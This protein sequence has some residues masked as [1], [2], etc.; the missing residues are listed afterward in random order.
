M[1][2][3]CETCLM[4][5]NYTKISYKIPRGFIAAKKR[6]EV[7]LDALLRFF[8]VCQVSYGSFFHNPAAA[9]FFADFSQRRNP[10]RFG[11][12]V[13]CSERSLRCGKSLRPGCVIYLTVL[14]ALRDRSV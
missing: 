14:I 3:P 10:L 5:L 1:D 2:N 4:I 9:L 11:K 6:I 12:S 13:C 7:S 8:A